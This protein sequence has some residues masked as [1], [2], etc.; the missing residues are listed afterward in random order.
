LGGTKGRKGE[1]AFLIKGKKAAQ[2]F[3]PALFS[4]PIIE[5]A[6]GERM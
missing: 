3:A 4:Q 2:N 6:R 5:G 1:N